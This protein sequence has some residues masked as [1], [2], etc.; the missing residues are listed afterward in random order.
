MFVF[1]ELQKPVAVKATAWIR[2]DAVDDDGDPVVVAF[3]WIVKFR[4]QTAAEEEEM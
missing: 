2:T 3:D 1:E 4:R